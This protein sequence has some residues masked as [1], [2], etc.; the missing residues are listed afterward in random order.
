MAGRVGRVGGLLVQCT[1]KGNDSEK[2]V[3][4]G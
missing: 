1:C 4:L 2:G 3:A